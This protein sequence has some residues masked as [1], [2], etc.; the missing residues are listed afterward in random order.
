MRPYI[1]ASF[2]GGKD[3]TA[4]VLHMLELGEQLDEVIFCDTYME[5][6]EMYE[7]VRK[8][9]EVI[10]AH[11]VKFTELRSEKSF[12]YW[13]LDHKPKTRKPEYDVL[14]YGW[15]SPMTRWC[16]KTMK[17]GVIAPYIKTLRE[18]H[19]VIQCIGLAADEGYRIERAHNQ[20]SGMRHP[21]VEWGWVEDRCLQYCY[22][23]G[24]DWGG[25]YNIYRRVSC[26]CCPLQRIGEL[27]KLRVHHPELWQKMRYLESRS[28]NPIRPEA[29]VEDLEVR[30]ALEEEYLARGES[31]TSRAFHRD[32]R[33][34]LSQE[35]RP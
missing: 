27:R 5:F 25:L 32:W 30:F 12:E 33:E 22:E 19:D 6:P 4:M 8:V 2:S 11:G 24:F 26:W 3:S 28:W 10:E 16:T 1:I 23:R 9:R 7:H 13:M 29:S 31:I 34:R 18:T 21:L 17:N 15:A 14:G 20:Q 35:V